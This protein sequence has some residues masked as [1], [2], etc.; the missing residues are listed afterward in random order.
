MTLWEFCAWG[1]RFEL[2]AAMPE[3]PASRRLRVW[4][5]SGQEVAGSFTDVWIGLE[6]GGLATRIVQRYLEAGKA[7]SWTDHQ[8]QI[9]KWKSLGDGLVFPIETERVIRRSGREPLIRN[10]WVVDD[11]R[12][13]V[14]Q[15][16]PPDALDFRFPKNALV[17][18]EPPE[19]G[20]Y[21]VEL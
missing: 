15:D 11:E 5:P 9:V 6:H 3:E 10:R 18:C 7:Q 16:L 13:I 4:H 17:R 12:L 21:R 19:G 20:R 1:R 2:L 14:N 8:T